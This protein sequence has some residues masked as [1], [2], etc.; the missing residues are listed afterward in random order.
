MAVMKMNYFLVWRIKTKQNKKSVK[1]HVVTIC[2][3]NEM[4][5]ELYY[6][7]VHQTEKKLFLFINNIFGISFILLIYDVYGRLAYKYNIIHQM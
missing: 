6:Y 7:T 3:L 1:V 2:I 4:K 5:Q